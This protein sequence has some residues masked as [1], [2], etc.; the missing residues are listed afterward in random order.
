MSELPSARGDG[1]IYTVQVLDGGRKKKKEK[2]FSY[3]AVAVFHQ[4][5]TY[6]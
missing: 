6:K 2:V 1:E 5:S 3:I 4:D